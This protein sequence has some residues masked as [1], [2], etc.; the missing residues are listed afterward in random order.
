LEFVIGIDVGGTCTDCVVL[1]ATGAIT[2]SKAFSTPPNFSDGVID[3]ARLAAADLGLDLPTLLGRTRLFLHATTIAENAILTGDLAQAGLLTTKGFEATLALMRGGYAEWAGRTEEEIKNIPYVYKPPPLIP[4]ALI[5]GIT[6]RV[7]VTGTVL[8]AA[9]REEVLDA[10]KSLIAA[11]ADAI[12]VSFLWGFANTANE[13]VA[14]DAI[15]E[16]DPD[17]FVTTSHEIAPVIGEFERTQTVALNIR[18]GPAVSRY[19]EHLA[20]QLR[21]NGYDGPM[22]VMQAYGGLLSA[23]LAKSRPVGMIESGPVSGL[24]GSKA[25]GDVLGQP[26]IIGI[27]MG[28]TTFKA[29]VISH[30]S[31]DYAREPMVAQYHYSSPKINM[32]SIGLAGGSIIHIDPDSGAPHVGPKSAGAS[33]GPVCYDRGG[34]EPTITDVDLLLGYLD[35]RYFLGGREPLNPDKAR[36]AFAA[37]VAEPLGLDLLDAAGE[38]YRLANS[39]I[40]DMLHKLTVERGLDPRE[41]VMFSSGGTAGMHVAAFAPALNVRS[42]VV[43]SSASV[44]SAL[45]LVTSDV[46][47]EEQVT[48]VMRV[49]ADGAAVDGV[50]RELVGNVAERLRADG[51]DDEDMAFTRAIEMRYRRQVHV[52][53]TPVEAEGTLTDDDVEAT[54]RRFESLYEE[55]FGEGSGYRE[56]GIE[57]VNFRVRGVGSLGKPQLRPGELGDD[58]PSAACVEERDAYFVS[59]RALL[60]APCYDF[61]KLTPGNRIDGPAIVWTPITT[62]VVNPGQAAFCDQFKNISITW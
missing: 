45:G 3:A 40:Y 5:R 37:K 55:R 51:F 8:A 35:E 50:L 24:V 33:P 52:V 46:A 60:R 26:N 14:V 22:L 9:K 25:L 28:G 48:H 47:H 43:P 15:R 36:A 59:E 19:L 34:E 18:L 23:D 17:L 2:I 61:Q 57:M 38:V 6:E 20:D 10:A 4:G 12:G 41:Y 11:G 54:V 29:G 21:E 13:R 49:P 42:V 39:M 56:A 58:D 53:T 16:V 27:D 1:D 7:D 30:G 32:E 44:H 31:I 62:V